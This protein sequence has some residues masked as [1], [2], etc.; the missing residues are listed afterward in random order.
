MKVVDELYQRV[1]FIYSPQ[2]L[3]QRLKIIQEQ[4]EQEI[5]LLKD[6]IQ[7]YEQKRQTEDA[8]YQSRSPLRKLFSGRPPNHHQ[9][10]EYLVHVKDRLNKI[11]RIKQ[12]ITT[13]QALILMI[14][15]GQ[16][17]AQIELPVSVI[18]ALTKIEKDQENH[19]DD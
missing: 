1:R 2:Q 5:V 11:K 16:T 9:A 10:V 14:E 8:L 6:K 7:K 18:D 13:L 17:Q 15:H 3:L 4:K 12:E 19:Y